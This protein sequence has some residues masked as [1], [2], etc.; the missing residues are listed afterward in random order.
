MHAGMLRHRVTLQSPGGD[1]NAIGQRYPVEWTDV[2]ENVPASISPI[3][4]REELIAA[5]RESSMSHILR[6]RYSRLWSSIDSTW[7]VLFGERVFTI[8][9]VKNVDER[10]REFVIE[11]IE[12]PREE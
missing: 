5:Q 9:S 8:E 3:S 4:G 7:R 11:C 2:A 12:G 10:N 1:Q 6:I